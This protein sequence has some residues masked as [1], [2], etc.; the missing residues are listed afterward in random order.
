MLHSD[1]APDDFDLFLSLVDIVVVLVAVVDRVV[2]LSLSLSNGKTKSC[3]A[4]SP[5]NLFFSSSFFLLLSSSS[6]FCATTPTRRTTSMLLSTV[7]FDVMRR[8]VCSFCICRR[9]P[10]ESMEKEETCGAFLSLPREEE[11]FVDVRGL[12]WVT[13]AR[14][15]PTGMFRKRK[16]KVSRSIRIFDHEQSD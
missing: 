8:G 12:C 7:V 6:F 9:I 2:S 15:W 14:C 16:A 11:T 3:S 10:I 1:R 13:F 5:W 4:R